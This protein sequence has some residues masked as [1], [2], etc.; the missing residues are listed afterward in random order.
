M[1]GQEADV[2]GREA[3]AKGG[4]QSSLMASAFEVQI[5]QL[6]STYGGWRSGWCA[7]PMKRA[8]VDGRKQLVTERRCV[9]R[10]EN[11]EDVKCGCDCHT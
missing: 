3:D 5:Y 1:V 11:R 7:K 9:A 8:G 6:D 2:K 10:K 4:E